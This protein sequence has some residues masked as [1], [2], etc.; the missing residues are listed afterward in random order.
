MLWGRGSD[1]ASQFYCTTCGYRTQWHSTIEA[2]LLEWKLRTV[3]LP[4]P[5]CGE[6]CHWCGDQEEILY[7]VECPTCKIRTSEYETLAEVANKWKEAYRRPNLLWE[8]L[9]AS[10]TF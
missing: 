4:C 10:T 3:G 2:A 9:D 7:W 8:L 5:Q 1:G 6:V